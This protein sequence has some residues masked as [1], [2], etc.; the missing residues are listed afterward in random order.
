MRKFSF[1]TILKLVMIFISLQATLAFPYS[2]QLD[3]EHVISYTDSGKGTVLVLIPAFPTDKKLWLPQKNLSRFFR[4]ITI[5]LPGFGQSSPVYGQAI[6]MT[7]YADVISQLLDQLHIKKSIIGGESMGGYI[8]LE[9]LNKYPDKVQGLILS[10]TQAIADSEEVKAKREIAAIDI[11]QNGTRHL[12]DT[13]VPTSLSHDASKQTQLFL[14]NIIQ[15]QSTPAIAS[16]L[17]GMAIRR[18]TSNIIRSTSVPIL[19]ITGEN[20]T[21]ISPKQS[22]NMHLLAKSSKLVVIA[23]AGHLSSLE[24]PKVWNRAVIQMFNQSLSQ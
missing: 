17:R 10:D 7:E 15:S 11:L 13:F 22:N 3:K 4:V 14:K 9:F 21:L 18:D 6:T 24:Q 2:M 12:I 1:V 8:A 16:A 23:K 20:D 19:I 5:D